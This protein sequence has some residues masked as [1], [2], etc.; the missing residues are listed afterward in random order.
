MQTSA[1]EV[2]VLGLLAVLERLPIPIAIAFDRQCERVQGNRAFRRLTGLSTSENASML[3]TERRALRY[4]FLSAGVPMPVDAMPLRRAAAEGADVLDVAVELVR[5]DG[6]H[7]SLIASAWPLRDAEGTVEGAIAVFVDVTESREAKKRAEQ[8][9]N[10]LLESERRYRLIT[11]A[12]PEFVWLDAPDGSA[13]Y[14]NRRWLEYTG[15]TEAQNEGLGWERVVHPDDKLRL[16]NERAR[17]LRTGDPYEGECRYR[18]RDGKYRWFLFRSIA[19]RDESGA[20]TSWLGTATDIDKQK[21]AEAQQTF[22]ALASDV[23]GSTLDVASTLDRI[24][25]LAIESLGTWCQIDLPDSEGN[26]RVAVVSHQNPGKNAALEQLVDQ[27]IYAAEAPFGPPSVFRSGK[28]E[29]L[30]RIDEAA[31]TAVIP[32]EA[33]RQ[34]YRKVGYAGGLMVP[35]RSG[36]RILGVLGIASDD[37]TRLYTEFDVATALELGRRG[38]SALENA[39]S[40]AR[41]HHVATTLQRAL[42][43]AT[44]PKLPQIS[45]DSAYA[46][47]AAEKG[48]AVGGD[49]YDAFPLSGSRIALSM[50]DVAGHGVDAAVTMS[51]VRLAIRAAALGGLNVCDVLARANAM[52]GLEKRA[53][54][55]T[56]LFGIYD[57]EQRTFTYALAGHPRPLIVDD[58]GNFRVLPGSGP[59]LGDAFDQA[60]CEERCEEI[61]APSTIVFFTDGLIEFKRDLIGA[62]ARLETVVKNRFFLSEERPAQ[63]VIDLVLDAPQRDDIAVLVMRIEDPA[64]EELNVT[65]PARGRSAPILRERLRRFAKVRGI[66]DDRCFRMLNAAGEAI[67]N[68]IEHAYSED[69]GPV[70]LKA[71]Y[72]NGTFK[73]SISD[74][75]LWREPT[76]S[77]GT[78]GRGRSIMVSLVNKLAFDKTDTGT[79]VRLEI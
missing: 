2:Y 72:E 60:L 4:H 58:A 74:R 48:E 42:L 75:G 59:P 45:F 28:P 55:V 11:E 23:L 29:L 16:E 62:V 21:R 54:M 63:A 10:A 33:H 43:P 51:T 46:S 31:V 27:N 64:A 7:Y 26:L 69:E 22:F 47:E 3:A 15:L 35:L 65:M 57:V 36:D 17:T 76:E 9:V 67:A 44:L 37:Q 34:V 8:A 61:P 20:V 79:T 18:G 73:V 41:E 71:R 50:G 6:A 70:T 14:S 12:M 32:D 56:A 24:A 1:F 13:I 40:Y 39:Q 78:R 30:A 53:G 77:E 52:I 38:A 25:H 68:A 66:D 19:V 5:Q 49:W